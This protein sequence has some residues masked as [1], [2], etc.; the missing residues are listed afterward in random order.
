MLQQPNSVCKQFLVTI[1]LCAEDKLSKNIIVGLHFGTVA[2]IHMSTRLCVTH[3]KWDSDL[4]SVLLHGWQRWLFTRAVQK[5]GKQTIEKETPKS[6]CV[7]GIISF[8]HA[9]SE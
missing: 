2:L 7:N 6:F 8:Q 1:K 5:Y 3:S 9:Q 4:E